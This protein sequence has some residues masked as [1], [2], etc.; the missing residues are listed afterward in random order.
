MGLSRIL[1]VT[2][3]R[4][5]KQTKTKKRAKWGKAEPEPEAAQPLL[6]CCLRVLPVVVAAA[7][8]III[9]IDYVSMCSVSL[10]VCVWMWM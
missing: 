7:D 5:G 6:A 3:C 1:P 9:T 2:S 4:V 10:Y 8:A